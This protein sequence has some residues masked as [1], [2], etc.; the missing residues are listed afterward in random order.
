MLKDFIKAYD[1]E[2][3]CGIVTLCEADSA[4]NNTDSTLYVGEVRKIPKNIRTGS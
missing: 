1:V 4:W 2:Y 3:H